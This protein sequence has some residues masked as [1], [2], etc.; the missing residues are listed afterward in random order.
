MEL[1]EWVKM[2]L[3]GAKSVSK[4]IKLQV[5]IRIGEPSERRNRS[6][7]CKKWDE[8]SHDYDLFALAATFETFEAL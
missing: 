8:E 3:E 7:T 2:D 1:K 4:P 5:E 6:N